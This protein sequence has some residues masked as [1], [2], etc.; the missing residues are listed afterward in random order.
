MN[1]GL[2]TS[3]TDLW[4]TPQDFFD[5]MNDEFHFELDVCANSEN[6]KCDQYF[7]EETDGL[8]QEWKGVCWMNP[9]YGREIGKWVK[10]AYESS[11]KG[12]TVVCLLPARTDTKWWHEY[13]MKGEIRLVK[14]R[15]KFGYSKNSAPFPSAIVIFGKQAKVNTVIAI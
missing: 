12:A 2:F 7:T 15:L 4:A 5:K 6:H 9:P 8:K 13:C 3:N 11:L 14:G 1:N 10:K